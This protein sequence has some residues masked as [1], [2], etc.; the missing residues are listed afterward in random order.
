MLLDELLGLLRRVLDVLTELLERLDEVVDVH[1][2]DLSGAAAVRRPL[3]CVD[4]SPGIS[5][6]PDEEQ[7]ANP[8]LDHHG[9]PCPVAAAF[10]GDR[11]T[12]TR[13]YFQETRRG[14]APGSQGR[15]SRGFERVV[16]TATSAVRAVHNLLF[17]HSLTWT[18]TDCSTR[19][20]TRGDFPP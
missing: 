14:L 18:D 7:S 4:Q 20:L 1:G 6:V 2:G 19:A 13:G 16:R 10:P 8:L 17:C 15:W 3:M 5:A 12:V 9:I 11:R